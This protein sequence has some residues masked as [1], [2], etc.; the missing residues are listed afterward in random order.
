MKLIIIS[1]IIVLLTVN[2]IVLIIDLVA[3][4]VTKNILIHPFQWWIPSILTGLLYY[5][6]NF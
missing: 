5:L 3:A 1:L 4:R 2:I 6:L